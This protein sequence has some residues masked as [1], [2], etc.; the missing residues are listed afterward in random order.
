[1]KP[2]SG[3]A[4]GPGRR[5]LTLL[6]LVTDVF[7]PEVHGGHGPNPPIPPSTPGGPPHP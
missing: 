1:M 7:E 4:I 2:T 5:R 6:D 3:S